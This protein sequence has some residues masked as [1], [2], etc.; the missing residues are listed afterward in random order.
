MAEVLQSDAELVE[1]CRRRDA[2]AFGL[3]IE[4]HQA[5]VFGVALAR[6]GDAAMAEDLAQDAF[7]VAWRDLDRLRDVNRV[8]SWIAGIARNLAF[9]RKRTNARRASRATAYPVPAPVAT[10]E[11]EAVEREERELVQSALMDVPA[12]HREALVL[13]YLEG[14]SVGRIAE[15]LGISEDLVKQRL[16][17]GRSALREGVAARVERTLSRMRP[18]SGFCATVV[19]AA[20]AFGKSDALAATTGTVITTMTAKTKIMTIGILTVVVAATA[21]AVGTND[22]DS[23]PPIGVP[24]MGIVD[25]PATADPGAT[26][27]GP[28]VRRM[29]DPSVRAALLERIRAAREQR[30][31]PMWHTGASSS[32]NSTSSGGVRAELDDKYA[33]AA[34]DRIMPLVEEC[35]R[36]GLE[37]I[38]WLGG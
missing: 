12:A 16:M 23:A 28:R 22:A 30:Q 9:D 31:D 1:R 27:S 38:P 33:M 7:V 26:S 6:C 11:D 34:L 36:E 24:S 17:R 14:E 20:L 21:V 18:S 3:L 29:T 15:L 4:R 2:A 25:H 10:P 13:F 5:L 8:G 32:T 35:Y 37:R 19:A